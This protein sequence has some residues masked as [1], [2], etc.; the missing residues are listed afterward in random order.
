MLG[1]VCAEEQVAAARLLDHLIEPW[2]IDGQ[3]VAV[4]RSNPVCSS[5][6]KWRVIA[7]LFL[8]LQ[9]LCRN[10]SCSVQGNSSTAA[11]EKSHLH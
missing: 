7:L 4:P 1:H 2:L 10:E 3:A 9:L 11:V 8:L 5:K 6:F